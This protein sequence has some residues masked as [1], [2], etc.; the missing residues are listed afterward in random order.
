LLNQLI[1]RS[2]ATGATRLP[3]VAALADSAHVAKNTMLASVRNQ[4]TL[5]ILRARPGGGLHVVSGVSP[6]GTSPRVPGESSGYRWQ[7]TARAI[8][9]D[10]LGG[11][12]GEESIPAAAALAQRH[13][14]SVPTLRKALHQ[15][16][17]EGMLTTRGGRYVRAFAA[18]R[19]HATILL[20]ARG[21]L[22]SDRAGV[23]AVLAPISQR[24]MENL[25][26]LEQY[27]ARIGLRLQHVPCF[28][29]GS[30]VHAGH[31]Q[32]ELDRVL[33]DR[34]VVGALLWC[35]ALSPG[36][37]A[38]LMQQLHARA[39][40]VAVL[41]EVAAIPD[42]THFAGLSGV[43]CHSLACRVEEGAAVGRY[44]LEQ[45]HR[46]IA[47]IAGWHEQRW[48]ANRL[49][50]LRQA[51]AAAGEGCEVI[52]CPA[53]EFE[54]V[55]HEQRVVDSVRGS[56][57][58]ALASQVRH[59]DGRRA[60]PHPAP[61]LFDDLRV[62]VFRALLRRRLQPAFRQAQACPGVTA[63]VGA[64]DAVALEALD[65]LR[66][67]RVA[68]PE[69]LSV[70]GFDNSMEG[71]YRGLTSYDF[72]G[73]ALVRAMVDQVVSSGTGHAARA[74]AEG[75]VMQRGTVRRL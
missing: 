43:S 40:A 46:R 56:L 39:L 13:G 32:S 7:R 1:L 38:Q 31:G 60:M 2:Q 67:Q 21:E 71:A 51:C 18:I 41:D 44:L 8:R 72:N 9:R 57:G 54:D 36:A 26:A 66:V 63:W 33:R 19:P 20:L 64:S 75:F 53:A 69:S 24:T 12:Y 11:F 52:A 37:V 50:G 49:E 68:V 22:H 70:I 5:G 42:P 73:P 3:S 29:E 25:R 55:G 16:T 45:G 59:P 65:F 28:Y 23:E 35:M 62:A 61:P 15:L 14:V 27:C 4:V 17:S 74:A 34:A 10:I 6:T 30:T 48:C 47:F 58:R